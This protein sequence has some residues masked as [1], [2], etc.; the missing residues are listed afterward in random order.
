M[1]IWIYLWI[2]LLF[3]V[4]CQALCP[5]N[6]FG[7]R[8][9]FKCHCVD[10]CDSEGKCFGNST[11]CS[12]RWFGFRC[13][14]RD[15]GEDA[16]VDPP[17]AKSWLS[18]GPLC[19]QGLSL[20][21][22]TLTWSVPQSFTWLRIAKLN[23]S[24][25]AN[26]TLKFRATNS[27]TLSCTN[28]NMFYV[29]ALTFDIRCDVNDAID[30]LT[31]ESNIV[32]YICSL[33]VSGGRNLAIFQSTNQSSTLNN[34]SLFS[35]QYAV[36]GVI[37]DTCGSGYCANTSSNDTTPSWQITFDQPYI[38]N[39]FFIYNSINAPDRLK[40]FEIHILDSNRSILFTKQ[41]IGEN[42]PSYT[43]LYFS[44]LAIA[45]VNIS[46]MYRFDYEPVPYVSINEFEAYGECVPGLWGLECNNLCKRECR[47]SCLIEDGSCTNEAIDV[48]D[49]KCAN[50]SWDMSQCNTTGNTTDR[51]ITKSDFGTGFGAGF[52]AGVAVTLAI[53]GATIFIWYVIKWRRS[54]LKAGMSVKEHSYDQ[55]D[56]TQKESHRYQGIKVQV[57]SEEKTY[58]PVEDAPVGVTTTINNADVYVNEENNYE[59]TF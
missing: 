35:A 56:I 38:L 16:S 7:Y 32:D 1:D 42:R 24:Y 9:Q 37:K 11:K 41:G 26:I 54:K 44:I 47:D 28:M 46:N 55:T 48:I 59:E 36:D 8:C 10:K 40:Y 21:R 19:Q 29:D 17:Q 33:R 43:V 57:S 4:Q 34:N 27:S 52:G 13:Q 51:F 6:Q 30:Q 18:E 25:A 50:R 5:D 12:P 20:I 14:Y 39:T 31:I 58:E 2:V 49:S 53:V 22:L 15:I 3:Y 23:I 45:A